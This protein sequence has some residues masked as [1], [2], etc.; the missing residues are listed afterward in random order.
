[1]WQNTGALQVKMYKIPF[2]SSRKNVHFN[3]P[4]L[5]IIIKIGNKLNN[6]FYANE[7][8]MYI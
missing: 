8:Y 6:T 7:L 5:K 4:I 3:D 2:V 1:M